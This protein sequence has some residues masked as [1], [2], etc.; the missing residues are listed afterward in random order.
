MKISTQAEQFGLEARTGAVEPDPE[1][2]KEAL[3]GPGIARVTY[4]Q[5]R[6]E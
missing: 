3:K 5:E 1:L 4:G 2:L 6:G